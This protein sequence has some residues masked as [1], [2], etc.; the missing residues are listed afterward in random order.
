MWG[1]GELLIKNYQQRM[2]LM[3]KPIE[4]SAIATILE[5]SGGTARL[6]FATGN[7]QKFYK[8]IGSGYAI[9]DRVLTEKRNGT[10]IV[11]GKL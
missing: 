3:Q 11:T 2:E 5:M 7:S 4:P 10:Y 9:G 1:A 8:M 6:T